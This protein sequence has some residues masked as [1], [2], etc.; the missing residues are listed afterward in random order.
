[1]IVAI[2]DRR[3]SSLD[4]LRDVLADHK[5]GERVAVRLRR[6]TRQLTL[7]VQLGRQPTQQR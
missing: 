2:G 3:V 5:P 1:M 7:E 6:G 4:E